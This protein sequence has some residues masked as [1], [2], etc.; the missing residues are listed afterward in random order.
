MDSRVIMGVILL[1]LQMSF[2]L[3]LILNAWRTRSSVGISLPTESLSLVGGAGWI[4]Y[5]ALAGAPVVGVSGALGALVAVFLVFLIL[6]SFSRK[7]KIFALWINVATSVALVAL[8]S[9]WGIPGLSSG[10]AVVALYQYAPQIFLSLSLIVKRT[11]AS[12]V[13]PAASFLRMVYGLA[14]V[15]YAVAWSFADGTAAPVDW[16]LVAWSVL[17]VT[18]YGL[19]YLTTLLAKHRVFA[20]PVSAV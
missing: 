16:P 2:S 20:S 6:D 7:E 9:M 10:L 19:Q 8:W 17:V 13:S 1:L 18:A 15:M 5:A 12:G 11:P 3:P 14:W 4:A